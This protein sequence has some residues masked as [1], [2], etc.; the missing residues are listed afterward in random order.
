LKRTG[1]AE[2]GLHPGRA[3]HWLT[4]KMTRL[5]KGIFDVMIDEI[6]ED[7]VMRRLGDPFWFQA[8]ANTLAYD[9]DS[10]GTTTVVCGILK[11]V[12]NQGESGIA[13]A[14]GKGRTSRKTPDEILEI[15]NRFG[16]STNM[17][18]SLKYSSRMA[19]KVDN[20]AI[21]DGY[22]LY[23]H[24]F[25]VTE[26]KRWAVI[27]Q[28]MN[29][30]TRM[31]R[32]YHWLSDRIS[33]PIEEP[34]EAILGH[35]SDKPVLDMTAKISEECRKT[36]TDLAK[37]GPKKLMK[38]FKSLR[39]MNQSSLAP[40]IPG[41]KEE[42]EKS[43][44]VYASRPNWKA[45]KRAYEI[46]P[47]DYEELLS[48]RG[49][50]PA[51]VRGLAM[52][53]DLIYGE[54]PSWRDPVKYTFAFGGKDGIPFPVNRRAMDEAIEI[55]ENALEQAKIDRREKLRMIERLKRLVYSERKETP[56]RGIRNR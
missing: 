45:L 54:E 6:G 22:R 10:S 5:A 18:E 2:L 8:L 13:L 29:T 53:S 51:T 30:D 48:I 28:G 25:I 50:G 14:G 40:W 42:R 34:H 36:S 19:A 47:K 43:L 24:T 11:N 1:T 37:E 3:P 4:S 15:G 12:L 9:W 38:I 17:I 16:F 32:R 49:I 41:L 26:S 52:V 39:P 20:T 44:D 56:N 55:L 35:R 21:Q 27:Q 23:H 33:N 31:A 7:E 46:D